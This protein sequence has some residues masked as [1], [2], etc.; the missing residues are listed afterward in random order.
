MS[1]IIQNIIKLFSDEII[2]QSLITETYSEVK[3]SI[4]SF[5]GKLP[6]KEEYEAVLTNLNIRD[7]LHISILVNEHVV[8]NIDSSTDYDFD[9]FINRI[10]ASI[11]GGNFKIAV[12]IVKVYSDKT[13][14]VYYLNQFI[15][16]LKELSINYFYE[17]ISRA[18]KVEPYVIFELQNDEEIEFNTKSI[19]FSNKNNTPKP[20]AYSKEVR[21]IKINR[22]KNI[23][24]NNIVSKHLLIPDD[25]YPIKSSN[26]KLTELFR[27]ALTIYSIAFLFDNFDLAKESVSYKLIG[28]KTLIDSVLI[29]NIDISNFENYYEIYLWVYN[30]GKIIDK[31]GLARNIISLNLDSKNLKIADTTFVSIKSSFIIYQKDNIKQYI[32]IRNKISDQ[33]IIL[34]SNADKIVDSYISDYKKSLLTV[35]SFFISIIVIKVVSK[36]DFIGGF[37]LEVT[38]LSIGLLAI[39]LMLLFYYKWEI[40]KQVER[41]RE[42]YKNLKTRH[43]DLLDESDL[44]RILNNDLDF[45]NNINYINQRILFYSKV[46]KYS[47]IIL[48]IIVILLYL[49]NIKFSFF[50]LMKQ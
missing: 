28:Y 44:K 7:S 3:Y 32:E 50:G 39:F 45:N 11:N 30:D 1:D 21:R 6:K 33:L 10:Y 34:Q 40:E 48:F 2:D 12:T 20:E 24:Y 41:Y 14:S 9:E 4:F 47:F 49:I 42:F 26:E 18:L 22:I 17:V 36:G 5:K 25:F 35:V 37:T 38:M 46:W 27:K 29:E 15:I 16:Y 13:Y 23:C 8:E 43:G 31:I 19:Y